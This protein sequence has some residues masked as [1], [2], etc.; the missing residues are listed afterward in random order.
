LP[1]AIQQLIIAKQSGTVDFYSLSEI[2]ARKNQLEF[3][4]REELKDNGK[5]PK[6]N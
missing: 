1:A 6:T 2:E 4:Y 5:L 3:L